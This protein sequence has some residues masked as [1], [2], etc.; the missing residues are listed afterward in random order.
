MSSLNTCKEI[1]E[2]LDSFKIGKQSIAPRLALAPMAGITHP[3][4]RELVSS[5]GGCGLYFSEM[6]SAKRVPSERKKNPPILRRGSGTG[7]LFYQVM[8][9]EPEELGKAVSL[10]ETPDETGE[11]KADGIDINMGCSVFGIRKSGAGSGLMMEPDRARRSV[12]LCR[13]KT[14]LPLTVKIRLGT[15]EDPQFLIRFAKALQDEGVDAI[16]LHPRLIKERFK[17]G[18]RWSFVGELKKNLT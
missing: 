1:A 16:T 18:A 4:F 9:S 17:R 2:N 14:T 11:R 10:L 15:N 12:A 5:F 3:A 7:P 8:G 6:L 13:K